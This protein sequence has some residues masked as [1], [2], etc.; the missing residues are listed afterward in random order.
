MEFPKGNSVNKIGNSEGVGTTDIIIV[1]VGVAGPALA[2]S[3]G[4]VPF[5]LLVLYFVL[6]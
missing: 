4:N 3:L 5:F 2:Y 1:G 6:P